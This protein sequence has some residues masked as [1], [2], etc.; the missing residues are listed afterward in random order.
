VVDADYSVSAWEQDGSEAHFAEGRL[1]DAVQGL[2]RLYAYRAQLQQKSTADPAL[3]DLRGEIFDRC[4]KCGAEAPEGLFT[5]TAPTGT[6]KT[7]AL[8]HFA[9][10]HAQATGK[11]R[12]IIVLPFLTLIEQSADTYRKILLIF[13]SSS[14]A[15]ATS[16]ATFFLI[17]S[18]TASMPGR[19][20]L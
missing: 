15:P 4:G 5:L 14:F 13:S 10:R 1:L 2:E 3:N 8:L 7:L 19:Q 9:L 17:S 20:S 12:I 6:G 18:D 16:S 11:R